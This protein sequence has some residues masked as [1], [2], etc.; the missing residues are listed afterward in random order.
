MNACWYLDFRGEELVVT[1]TNAGGDYISG[2]SIKGFFLEQY[3]SR[4][5]PES[6]HIA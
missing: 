4:Q 3:S 2:K 5:P 6:L 1:Q